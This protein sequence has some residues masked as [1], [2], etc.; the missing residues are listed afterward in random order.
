ME[1]LKKQKQNNHKESRRSYVQAL[2]T[3][4]NGIRVYTKIS[5]VRRWNIPMF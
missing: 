1:N 2:E 4:L 3:A 5:H